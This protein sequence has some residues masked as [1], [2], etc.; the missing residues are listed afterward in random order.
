MNVHPQQDWPVRR[1]LWNIQ[2]KSKVVLLLNK[3]RPARLCG[4]RGW[5]GCRLPRFGAEAEGSRP[6]T[7]TLGPLS[8]FSSAHLLAG[9]P[10][11]LHEQA[12]PSLSISITPPN[13]KCHR[14]LF[15]N[16]N[17][18]TNLQAVR[19]WRVKK[20]IRVKAPDSGLTWWWVSLIPAAGCR[21][22]GWT[23]GLA[24]SERSPTKAEWGCLA[25]VIQSRH[26][27]VPE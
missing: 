26:P 24:T 2:T 20:G 23:G 11:C 17:W 10:A 7:G 4:T 15:F 25:A 8:A 13:E 16:L 12:L 5:S 22:P 6:S 21:Q 14:L 9:H 18:V 19:D 1:A 3:G 27:N